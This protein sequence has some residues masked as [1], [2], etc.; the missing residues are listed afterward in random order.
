[1]QPQDRSFTSHSV[2]GANVSLKVGGASWPGRWLRSLKLFVALACSV[3]L[4]GCLLGDYTVIIERSS[5]S[6]DEAALI[7]RAENVYPPNDQVLA[8]YVGDIPNPVPEKLWWYTTA[9]SIQIPYALTGDSVEYYR[10]LVDQWKEASFAPY[11]V[12]SLKYTAGVQ[13]GQVFQC[14]TETFQNVSVVT[15][16]MAWFCWRNPMNAVGFSKDRLTVFS[17]EGEILAVVGDGRSDWW[18]A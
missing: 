8:A 16:H 3:W 5:M 18:I 13:S 11:I 17:A 6:S 1:M 12:A 4:T 10:Q 9:D 7:Q 15:M 14:G 2:R